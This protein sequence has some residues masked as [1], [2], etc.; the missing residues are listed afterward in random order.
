MNKSEEF[1]TPLYLEILPGG[2]IGGTALRPTPPGLGYRL[3]TVLEPIWE[4]QPQ[5]AGALHCF[6][7]SLLC[8]P[9]ASPTLAKGRCLSMPT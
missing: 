8:H 1:N 5:S 9:G 6:Q 4:G 2:V 3:E 7:R